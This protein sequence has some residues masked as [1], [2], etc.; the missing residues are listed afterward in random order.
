LR[1]KKW[2]LN[3]GPKKLA[4]KKYEKQENHIIIIVDIHHA[5]RNLRT[6]GA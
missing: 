1:L 4:S 2:G 3:K 6:R 5:T